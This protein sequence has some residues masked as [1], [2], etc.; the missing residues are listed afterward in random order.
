MSTQSDLVS[1]IRSMAAGTAVDWSALDGA[2]AD[3]SVAA[4]LDQLKVIAKIADVHGTSGTSV[5]RPEP[6]STDQ[7][8]QS[9]GPLTLL[10]RI[11]EGSYGV[12]YRAW[13]SRLDRDVALKLLRPGRTTGD[14][15]S[16]TIKEGRLLARVRHPNVVTV[17]GADCVDGRIGIWMEFVSG[18]TLEEIVR[19][20]G[21]LPPDEVARIGIEVARGLSAVHRAGIVHRDVKAQNVMV[22]ADGRVV[23]MD[24][25]SGHELGEGEKSAAGTP[26]YVAPEVL[27]GSPATARSDIYSLGVLLYYAVTG[28]YPRAGSTVAELK[29]QPSGTTVS[30]RGSHPQLPKR[31]TKIVERALAPE[32]IRFRVVDEVERALIGTQKHWRQAPLAIAAAVVAVVTAGALLRSRNGPAPRF[33][34]A[35]RHQWVIVTPL[36]NHTGDPQ[37]NNLV[38]SAFSRELGNGTGAS[39]IPEQRVAGTLSLMRRPSATR[40]EP[41]IAREIALR[42]GDVDAV[43]TPRLD[44][45]GG[46]IIVSAEAVS[47]NDGNT[48]LSFVE[49]GVPISQLDATVRSE[50]A[51]LRKSLADRASSITPHQ[52]KLRRV[53]SP[54][55]VAVQEYSQAA[56]LL[57]DF[58]PGFGAKW[59]NAGAQRHLEIALREDPDFASAHILMAHVISNQIQKC[60]TCNQ[61]VRD[62]QFHA[63][64]SMQL[65]A[66]VTSVERNFILGSGHMFRAQAAVAPAERE[67][68]ESQAI[69]GWEAVVRE[70]PDFP[71]ALNNIIVEYRG[72]RHPEKIA[73]HLAALADARPDSFLVNVQAALAGHNV[74]DEALTDRYAGRSERLMTT[75]Q[76]HAYPGQAAQLKLL[77]LETAW[78]HDDPREMLRRLN[79]LTD[80]VE[81]E[82]AQAQQIVTMSGFMAALTL[83]RLHDAEVRVAQFPDKISH[84]VSFGRLLMQHRDAAAMH[85]F[86]EPRVG[87]PVALNIG[88]WWA[89]NGFLDEARRVARLERDL[90]R[91]PAQKVYVLQFEE[92]IAVNEHRP[93]DAVRVAHQIL[94]QLA[95]GNMHLMTAMTTAN[96][97]VELGRLTDAIALLEESTAHRSAEADVAGY[98]WM[99]ARAQL[100]SVYHRVGREAEARA[101]EDHLLRLLVVADADHPLLLE[102]K[103]RAAARKH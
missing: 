1:A 46:R 73:A 21:P 61:Q 87:S 6:A 18:R 54:S 44:K 88:I 58:V 72:L 45:V 60:E 99:N 94:P 102:L 27:A 62:V 41:A 84:D 77:M 32:S 3:A 23:L 55:L 14:G 98:R 13:D 2:P 8:V 74:Q 49:P 11:G 28:S 79:V 52:P 42:D 63:E 92:S 64:R 82:P 50:V 66:T 35:P 15:D 101:V 85:A 65:A 83:G 96:A 51:H 81:G 90:A 59:D 26:L 9:W 4:V 91:I 39:S 57:P 53:T 12:V 86:L 16:V 36:E 25:G 47:P 10:E 103:A 100:A 76:E 19:T 20:G 31:F 34:E 89:E 68:E 48:L 70:Q 24:F 38:E 5:P 17:H 56:G 97:L 93:E 40:L 80:Q 75:D 29:Q 67:S 37:L 95:Y 30:M 78:L 7:G 43:I 71:W 22:Q 69:A 33:V